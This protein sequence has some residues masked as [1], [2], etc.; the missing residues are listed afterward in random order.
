MP[1]ARSTRPDP[2]GSMYRLEFTKAMRL[3]ERLL[4]DT[5]TGKDEH[6]TT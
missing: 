1:R 3:N 6:A 2:T 4:P 5:S